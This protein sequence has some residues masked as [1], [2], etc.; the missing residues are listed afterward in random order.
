MSPASQG[1]CGCI[2]VKDFDWSR[3][4]FSQSNRWILMPEVHFV[5]SE[6]GCRDTAWPQGLQQGLCSSRALTHGQMP[7]TEQSQHTV[8]ISFLLPSNQAWILVSSL[9]H[10]VD[11]TLNNYKNKTGWSSTRMELL[12]TL[13]CLNIFVYTWIFTLYKYEEMYIYYLIGLSNI[14][15]LNICKWKIMLCHIASK[16]P[17]EGSHLYSWSGQLRD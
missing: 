10:T 15:L 12:F 17:S 6:L 9:S 14:T 3:R 5:A 4:K 2:H 8:S 1:L 11:I 7:G 16:T 13:F